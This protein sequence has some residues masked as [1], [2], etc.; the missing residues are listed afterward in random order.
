ME[1]L[2]LSWVAGRKKRVIRTPSIF[3][4]M[5]PHSIST[6][7]PTGEKKVKKTLGSHLPVSPTQFFPVSSTKVITGLAIN[8]ESFTLT[9]SGNDTRV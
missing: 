4:K 3:R 7:T 1:Q 8:I 6:S 9:E 2:F 5:K